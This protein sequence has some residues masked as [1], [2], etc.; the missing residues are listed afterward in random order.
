MKKRIQ[1]YSIFLS[2]IA[3]LSL[4]SVGHAQNAQVKPELSVTPIADSQKAMTPISTTLGKTASW[5]GEK[6]ALKGRDV[7]SYHQSSKSLKGKKKYSANWDSST[8]RFASEE[9]RDLF[10]KNPEKYTPQFGGY[11]PVALADNHAKVGLSKH[12]TVIDEKLYLNYNR[13]ARENFR[14]TPKE[15]IVRAQLN[16]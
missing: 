16:F 12:Y 9:N 8:W 2:L 6:V 7:V 3:G 1:S 5:Q 13:G 10:L 14:A 4:Y 11:C 15:Y